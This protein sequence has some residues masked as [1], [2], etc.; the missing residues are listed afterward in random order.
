MRAVRPLTAAVKIKNMIR[1]T[2]ERK[3]FAEVIL[4]M[5]ETL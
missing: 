3:H 1:A 2:K 5:R 4:F